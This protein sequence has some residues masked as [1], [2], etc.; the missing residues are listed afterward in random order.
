MGIVRQGEA[1]RVWGGAQ[2]HRENMGFGVDNMGIDKAFGLSEKSFQI[3]ETR[4]SRSQCP[5]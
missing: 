2:I 1:S 5:Y 4:I 3:N